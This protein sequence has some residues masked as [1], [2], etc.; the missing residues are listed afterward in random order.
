MG[1][2]IGAKIERVGGDDNTENA[3]RTDSEST[4]SKTGTGTPTGTGT[5]TGTSAGTGT[6]SGR[7]KTKEVVSGLADVT[8]E[9][10]RKRLERNAKRR[11]AY[12]RKKMEQGKEYKPKKVNSTTTKK[13]QNTFATTEQ[14]TAIL[15]TISMIVASR[16]ECAHWQL[17][18][19]EIESLATP[20]SNMISKSDAISDLAEHSD[21]IALVTACAT[22]FVPRGIISLQNRKEKKQKHETKRTVTNSKRQQTNEPNGKNNDVGGNNERNNAATDTN[23]GKDK[24]GI[25][26][27]LY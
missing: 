17:T 18:P 19:T 8:D 10:E 20:I 6:S 26:A 25:S 13:S 2:K 14:I 5:G 21:A 9:E 3:G 22:I 16:P 7:E 23:A 27:V 1:E 11:E 12:A 15:S 24:L 4:N